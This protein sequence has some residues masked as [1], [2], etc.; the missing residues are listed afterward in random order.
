MDYS[1]NSPLT[2]MLTAR[3]VHVRVVGYP[4]A[5]VPAFLHKFLSSI[6]AEIKIICK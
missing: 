3:G 5:K 4:Q 1:D 6:G 2:A